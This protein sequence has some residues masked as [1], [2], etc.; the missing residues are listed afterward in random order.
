MPLAKMHKQRKVRRGT[1][2]PRFSKQKV[3]WRGTSKSAVTPT[4]ASISPNTAVKG[5]ADLTMTCTGTGYVAGVTRIVF[6]G[7]DEPTTFISATQ[8]STVVKPST[9]TVAGA[10]PVLVRNGAQISTTPRTFTFT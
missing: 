1:W 3:I 10:Y 9:V 5:G 6:N 8:V 2:K 7:G 4:L